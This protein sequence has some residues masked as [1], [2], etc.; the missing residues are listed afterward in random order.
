MLVSCASL[1]NPVLVYGSDSVPPILAKIGPRL[2]GDDASAITVVYAEDRSC[3]AVKAAI[4]GLAGSFNGAEIGCYYDGEPV[5]GEGECE[6]I[7]ARPC[8]LDGTMAADI[9]VSDVFPQTCGETVGGSVEHRKGPVQAAIF[10]TTARS[11]VQAISQKAAEAVY[12]PDSAEV[13]PPWDD[14]AYALQRIPGSGTQRLMATALG[15][16]PDQLMRGKSLSSSSTLIGTIEGWNESLKGAEV[17]KVLGIYDVSNADRRTKDGKVGFRAL[18][19]K[20][21]GADCGFL[22][23]ASGYDKAHVRDGQYPIWSPLHFVARKDSPRSKEI[24]RVLDL[25]LMDPVA[26]VVGVSRAEVFATWVSRSFVPECAMAVQRDSE[27]GALTPTTPTCTCAFEAVL[28]V[29][30]APGCKPCDE[31]S[32]ACDEGYHCD[33]RFGSCEPN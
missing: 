28:K 22:P 19:F 15:V 8:A 18:A 26:A 7:G 14:E 31:S 1:P 33:Y 4:G 11:S 21:E 2:A 12:S 3:P 24:K 17:D 6:E 20:A 13:A 9:G 10:V 25:V 5:S 29:A 30:S 23:D 32:S 27:M 16:D